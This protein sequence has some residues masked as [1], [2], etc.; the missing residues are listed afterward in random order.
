MTF[1]RNSISGIWIDVY[2]ILFKQKEAKRGGRR[3]STAWG[4]EAPTAKMHVE[5][6][7]QT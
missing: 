7:V 4:I 2:I 1:R 6:E 5:A 3:S